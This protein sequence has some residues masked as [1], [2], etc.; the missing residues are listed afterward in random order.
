M[1]PR[2]ETGADRARRSPR[3]LQRFFFA[4]SASLFSAPAAHAELIP[5]IQFGVARTDNLTLAAVDPEAQTVY[6]L[7]PSL[8]YTNDAPRFIADAEYEIQGY[9]YDQRDET[10]VFHLLDG[11]FSLGLD[12]DNLFLD[13]GA[14]R[15]Q[16]IDDPE[17]TIPHGNLPISSNRVDVDE[18]YAGPR[19]FYPIGS[20]VTANAAYQR[21][22]VRYRYDEDDLASSRSDFDDDTLTFSLD[23]YRREQG[24]TWATRYTDY[25]TTYDL[26]LYAPWEYRQATMEIGGWVSSVVRLFASGGRESAWDAPLDPSLEDSF[27]EAGFAAERGESFSA[28]FAAGERTYGSS[29]RGS[30]NYLFERGGTTLSYVESPTT[31]GRNRYSVEGELEDAEPPDDLLTR[32]GTGERYVS[33]RLL[34]RLRLDWD[35]TGFG[36]YV[37]DETRENRIAADGT[38]L[39]DEL[40]SGATVSASWRPGARTEFTLDVTRTVREFAPGEEYRGDSISLIGDYDIG[41]RTLLSLELSRVEERRPAATAGYEADL[42]ALFLTRTF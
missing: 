34:W 31:Q 28:E 1:A 39:G 26:E 12:P 37:Y 40:Q 36:V 21:A 4:C 42:I 30:L 2:L 15:T 5:E 32:P 18:A 10:E 22:I 35:R 33:K 9:R 3:F 19:L 41:S 27:W 23:N 20:N 25:R 6:S 17:G 11:V 7:V 13:F 38:P 24:F 16:A 29:R 14:S 8:I